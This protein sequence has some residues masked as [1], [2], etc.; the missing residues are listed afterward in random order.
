MDTQP[1]TTPP[2]PTASVRNDLSRRRFLELLSAGG[3]AALAW[4]SGLAAVLVPMQGI[5]N[6]L[7]F[8][9]KDRKSVV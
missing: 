8:Y 9:P 2:P 4:R 6:P 3:A 5:D 7:A 1:R